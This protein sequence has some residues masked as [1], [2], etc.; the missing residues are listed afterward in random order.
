M[1]LMYLV[2]IMKISQN[3]FELGHFAFFGISHLDQFVMKWFR[4]FQDNLLLFCP[5]LL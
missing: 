2:Y 1:K 3:L 5:L 4:F